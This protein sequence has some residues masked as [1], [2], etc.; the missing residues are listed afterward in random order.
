MKNTEP[1]SSYEK[2]LLKYLEYSLVQQDRTVSAAISESRDLDINKAETI[3]KNL[4]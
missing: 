2:Q 3:I 4:K 1:L